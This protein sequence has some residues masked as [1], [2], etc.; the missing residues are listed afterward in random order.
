MPGFPQ[1]PPGFQGT[2][3]V[4]LSIEHREFL[5]VEDEMQS[6]IVNHKDSG[7]AGGLFNRYN[8]IKVQKI[9]NRK[10]WERYD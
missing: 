5:A 6:T 10:L 4:P 7:L 3:L 1:T 8:V 9:F 2:V